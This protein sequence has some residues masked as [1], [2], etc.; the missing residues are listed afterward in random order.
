MKEITHIIKEPVVS[1]QSTILNEFGKY[2]FV[3]DKKANKLE[4]KYA[5]EKLFDVHVQ[6]VNTV[7]V[8]GKK[9]RMRYKIGK[10]SDW[11]KAIVT[12]SEGE[13]IE[14]V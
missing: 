6:K 11:K 9:R 2:V 7:N 4:I 1:E 12:L 3:V 8:L 5:I 14:F 13:K 10:R